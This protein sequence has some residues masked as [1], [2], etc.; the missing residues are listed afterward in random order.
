MIRF[1]VSGVSPAAEHLFPVRNPKSQ[2]R[3]QKTRNPY[4]ATRKGFVLVL[5]LVLVTP[6][7]FACIFCLF[8]NEDENDDE[9]DG[10]N[11]VARN[12]QTNS[13]KSEITNHKSKIEKP[14]L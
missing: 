3:N 2:L 14:A 7:Y 10:F 5:V 8:E 11:P 12:P 6:S 13:F 9:D 1:R 4:P